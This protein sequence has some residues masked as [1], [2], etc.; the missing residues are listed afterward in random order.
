MYPSRKV[1]NEAQDVAPRLV[2]QVVADKTQLRLQNVRRQLAEH[3]QRGAA[4]AEIIDFDHEAQFAQPA[5][6]LDHLVRVFHIGALG[7]FQMQARGFQSLIADDAG[8]NLLNVRIV[9]VRAGDVYRRRNGRM[10]RIAQTR[11]MRQVSRH[12]YWSRR[13]MKPFFSKMGMNSAGD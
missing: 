2:A 8:Q 4:A 10:S 12:T 6:G 13:V 11:G 1:H 9:D 3:V 7:D 5:H